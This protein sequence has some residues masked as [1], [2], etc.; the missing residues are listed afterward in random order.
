MDFGPATSMEEMNRF[1]GR[2]EVPWGYDDLEEKVTAYKDSQAQDRSDTWGPTLENG[3]QRS[4]DME[5][6]RY[7]LV[8]LETRPSKIR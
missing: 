8:S 4:K 7:L 5:Y 1:L 2:S 3:P 6:F